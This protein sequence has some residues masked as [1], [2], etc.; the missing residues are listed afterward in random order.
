[1]SV[2]QLLGDLKIRDGNQRN[3]GTKMERQPVVSSNL[4]SVGYEP[5]SETLEVEFK[6]GRIYQYYNVPQVVFDMLIMASS[7]GTFF[8][9]N[10][11]D[12]FAC[13]RM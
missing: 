5:A 13:A 2:F 4:M 1:M 11:R 3:K 7:P 9:A 10:I 8:N 12:S 6:N